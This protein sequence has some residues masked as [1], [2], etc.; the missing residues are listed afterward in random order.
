MNF[1]NKYANLK[2]KTHIKKI[3]IKLKQLFIDL[4]FII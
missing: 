3:N 4:Y 1:K 2:T